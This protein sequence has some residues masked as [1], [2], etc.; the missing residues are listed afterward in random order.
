MEIFDLFDDNRLPLNKTIERG[1]K[2]PPHENR[3]LV[4]VCI[5]NS[6]N[7]MLIQQRQKTKTWP[8]RWDIS[9]G[10]CSISGENSRETAKR[11]LF[12]EL[13]IEYDF[14]NL[15][16]HLTINFSSGFDDL[17]LIKLD[18]DLKDLKLQAEE[19]QDADWASRERI[20][21]MIASEEFV[22]YVST[23]IDSLFDLKNQRGIMTRKYVKPE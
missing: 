23:F 13:G 6:K 19:V 12:E 16:P 22:P 3:Q 15:R 2:C 1:Q 20:K 14:S 18:V 4:H 9:L 5:F 7:E 10:G 17:Y 21:E 8:N 11:E